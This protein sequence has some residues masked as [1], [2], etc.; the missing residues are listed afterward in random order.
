MPSIAFHL[1][2][3]PQWEQKKENL[4][5]RLAKV[6]RSPDHIKSISC[7]QIPTRGVWLFSQFAENADKVD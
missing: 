4:H 6:E 2:A 7:K 1:G 3:A 5:G